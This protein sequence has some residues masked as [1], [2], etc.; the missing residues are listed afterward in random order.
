MASRD[1]RIALT[2]KELDE[3]ARLKDKMKKSY[4]EAKDEGFENFH[5]CLLPA[6]PDFDNQTDRVINEPNLM[7]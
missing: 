6:L 3:M 4:L 5:S 7:A 1:E 2:R